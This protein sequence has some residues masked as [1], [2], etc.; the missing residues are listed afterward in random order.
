MP[1]RL[2]G[3]QKVQGAKF[4]SQ[5][6]PVSLLQGFQFCQSCLTV[7]FPLIFCSSAAIWACRCSGCSSLSEHP[8]DRLDIRLASF[9]RAMVSRREYRSP[10][11]IADLP[12]QSLA[13][14]ANLPRSSKSAIS[15]L[16]SFIWSRRSR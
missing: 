9:C 8:S 7:P 15:S 2:T 6:F 14:R 3:C 16:L 11:Q 12:L 13:S 10:L 1:S 4:R 5:L